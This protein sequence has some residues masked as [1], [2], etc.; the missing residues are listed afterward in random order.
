MITKAFDRAFARLVRAFKRHQDA[1]RSPEQI[2]ILADAR[3]ELH[4]AR[5]AVAAERREVLC[6]KVAERH[7]VPIKERSSHDP[8]FSGDDTWKHFIMPAIA[9]GYYASPALMRLTRTGMLEV[10]GSDYIRTAKAKGVENCF[11]FFAFSL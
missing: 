11:R 10:L 9:L 3:W 1:P 5:D 7:I 6:H 2:S 4:L 8:A